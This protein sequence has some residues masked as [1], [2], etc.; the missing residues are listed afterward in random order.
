MERKADRDGLRPLA[1]CDS[2]QSLVKRQVKTAHTLAH[3][4][5]R[6]NAR[7]HTHTHTHTHT[8]THTHTYTQTHTRSECSKCLNDRFFPHCFS[9]KLKT[10][11]NKRKPGD[12]TN[13]SACFF[14]SSTDQQR[15][16][17][18]FCLGSYKSLDD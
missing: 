15:C 9:K 1:F 13:D 12:R 4:R 3:I 8:C 5:V 16:G 7:S 2:V 6:T 11:S 10:G 14:G 18:I 17:A